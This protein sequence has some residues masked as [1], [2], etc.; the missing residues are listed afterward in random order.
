MRRGRERRLEE[1]QGSDVMDETE[2]KKI[3]RER[4]RELI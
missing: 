2:R 4:K 3:K 1:R